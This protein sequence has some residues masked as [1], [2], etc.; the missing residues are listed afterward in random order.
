[1]KVLRLIPAFL[2]LLM[3]S[4]ESNGFDPSLIDRTIQFKGSVNNLETRLANDVW[5][6]GDAMGIFMKENNKNFTEEALIAANKKYVTQGD[7]TFLPAKS[8]DELTY[9]LNGKMVDFVAIYPYG[10]VN[11]AHEYII[12]IENQQKQTALDF[13]LSTNATGLNNK[14]KEVALNFERQMVK[15]IVN[16]ISKE[17]E[18]KSNAKVNILNINTKGVFSL[19]NHQ[20]VQSNRADI[21]MKIDKKEGRAEAIIM[22]VSTVEGIYMEIVNGTKGYVFELSD[23]ANFSEFVAGYRYTLNVTLD[24]DTPDLDIGITASVDKWKEGETDDMTLSPDF[25]VEYDENEPGNNEGNGDMN[26]PGDGTERSP[27]SIEQVQDRLGD[28]DVWVKGYIV[29]FYSGVTPATFVPAEEIIYYDWTDIKDSHIAL[30]ASPDETDG[31][32]TFSVELRA[33]KIR[34]A[35]NIRDNEENLGRMVSVYGGIETYMKLTG[36]K[37]TKD[38]NFIE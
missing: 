16:L 28:K 38:Y 13:L 19:V 21:P 7:G 6:K 35:L 18:L 32:K 11:A 34:E 14:D 17:G 20:L 27:Y 29:G 23:A 33:G 31:A 37:G 4:C 12:N 15:L 3:V 10:S 26:E 8:A 1:M 5:E 2:L 24:G 36:M 25:N 22:P 9:P 30:A